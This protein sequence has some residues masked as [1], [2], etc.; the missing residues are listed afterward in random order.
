MD[1][2]VVGVIGA[3][4]NFIDAVKNF[5]VGGAV[6]GSEYIGVIAHGVLSFFDG[7]WFS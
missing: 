6:V 1:F 5:A 3:I 7:Y 4:D 2:L